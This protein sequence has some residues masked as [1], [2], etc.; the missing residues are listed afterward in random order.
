MRQL[1]ARP[2]P[3]SSSPSSLLLEEVASWGV[4]VH[5]QLHPAAPSPSPS[6]PAHTNTPPTNDDVNVRNRALSLAEACEAAAHGQHLRL[7]RLELVDV[8]LDDPAVDELAARLAAQAPLLRKLSL[9]HN[10]VG[11][12][13]A[14]ALA[15]SSLLA[16]LERLDLNHNPRL[17][18]AG[19]AALLAARPLKLQSLSMQHTG[20]G[21]AAAQTL[22]QGLLLGPLTSLDISNN[23]HS[24]GAAA[25]RHLVAALAT[26]W[27]SPANGQSQHPNANTAISWLDLSMC[28]LSDRGAVEVAEL[29]LATASCRLERYA[30]SIHDQI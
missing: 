28:D 10:T 15:R 16:R 21:E 8:G 22:A 9:A 23:P 27:R 26:R 17:G 4:H 14:A 12:V 5:V 7:T 18:D 3:A 13:G 29:F 30:I 25:V 1:F 20:F 6:P 19:A 2:F 24:L 11:P